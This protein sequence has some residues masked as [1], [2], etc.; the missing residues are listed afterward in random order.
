M[1][2]DSNKSSTQSSQKTTA[3]RGKMTA[4]SRHILTK[5]SISTKL[6]ECAVGSRDRRRD[7][8]LL[9]LPSSWWKIGG[10]TRTKA[11]PSLFPSACPSFYSSSGSSLLPSVGADLSFRLHRIRIPLV[12]YQEASRCQWNTTDKPLTTDQQGALVDIIHRFAGMLRLIIDVRGHDK[13]HVPKR[14]GFSCT[15]ERR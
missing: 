5:T 14:G 1:P 15:H 9:F 6:S 11:W 10:R 4:S 13:C 2:N 7:L 8:N 3:I 12:F